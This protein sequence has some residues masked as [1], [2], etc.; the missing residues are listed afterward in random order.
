MEE[1]ELLGR[2]LG[3]DGDE[4]VVSVAEVAARFG[5]TRSAVRLEEHL[6]VAQR[7]SQHG[8]APEREQRASAEGEGGAFGT[9]LGDEAERLEGT[10]LG[11]LLW[12]QRVHAADAAA[13]DAQAQ[14]AARRL[15]SA[16]RAALGVPLRCG[17]G[18][19]PFL[20]KF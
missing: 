20:L 11:S 16:R 19:I 12:P 1:R 7:A 10:P 5:D 2:A 15:V 13:R 4:R 8:P 3:W 14:Q 18:R 6:R 9:L 17:I